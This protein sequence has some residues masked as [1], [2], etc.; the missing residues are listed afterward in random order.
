MKKM[1]IGAWPYTWGGCAEDPVPLEKVVKTL[2]EVPDSLIAK[3][4]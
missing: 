4:G 1:S 3:H 2:K